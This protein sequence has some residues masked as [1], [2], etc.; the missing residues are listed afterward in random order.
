[1][2]ER[3]TMKSSSS[4]RAIFNEAPKAWAEA[5]NRN[6]LSQGLAPIETRHCQANTAGTDEQ[7]SQTQFTLLQRKT[8]LLREEAASLLS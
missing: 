2:I 1:M 4:L 5:A 7:V 8:E 3:S 6:R